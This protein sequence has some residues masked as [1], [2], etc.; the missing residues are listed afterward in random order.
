MLPSAAI[1]LVLPIRSVMLMIRCDF[2]IGERERERER[3]GSSSSPPSSGS[4]PALDNAP[5]SPVPS[6]SPEVV[7]IQK[8]IDMLF[9]RNQAKSTWE[10]PRPPEVLGE[11]LDSRHMLP[12][13]LPSDPRLLG[14]VPSKRSPSEESRDSLSHGRS[15][16]RASL[17]STSAMAWRLNSRKLREVGVGTLQWVDGAISASRWYRRAQVQIAEEEEEKPPPPYSSD[18]PHRSF[19]GD[20]S[21][22][23]NASL[24]L[25]S[26]TRK[27]S[28]RSRGGRASTINGDDFGHMED[29]DDISVEH[30]QS[31]IL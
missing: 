3:D 11:L 20:E 29:F 26:L 13:M 19:E 28:L 21:S 9:D 23:Y 18:D 30:T 4:P 7:A 16:S 31:S 6:P 1:P 25:T 15:A 12:L 10:P 27:P 8:G 17:G 2:Q 22:E 24:H 14:A 5:P